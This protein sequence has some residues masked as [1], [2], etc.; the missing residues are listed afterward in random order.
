MYEISCLPHGKSRFTDAFLSQG[1]QTFDQGKTR[2][3][4]RESW[5]GTTWWGKFHISGSRNLHSRDFLSV[6]TASLDDVVGLLTRGDIFYITLSLFL[7]LFSLLLCA[8]A[9]HPFL[10]AREKTFSFVSIFSQWLRESTMDIIIIACGGVYSLKSELRLVKNEIPE[11]KGLSL[12]PSSESGIYPRVPQPHIC[13]SDF[14]ASSR[15]RCTAL[16]LRDTFPE[17]IIQRDA[18]Q[19]FPLRSGV[20]RLAV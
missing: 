20:I 15:Y 16:S 2:P 12:E 17:W 9:F 11:I 13:L 7:A 6:Q 18:R 19:S 10:C 8:L 4:E 5:L 3:G 1:R 14:P